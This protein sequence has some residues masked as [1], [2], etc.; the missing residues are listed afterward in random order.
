MKRTRLIPAFLLVVLAACQSPAGEPQEAVLLS[1]ATVTHGTSFGMCGGYCVSELVVDG[2]TVTFT[3]RSHGYDPAPRTRQVEITAAEA[4][5]IASLAT[6][7][8]VRPVAGV[9]G[10]PDCADGGAE[11]IEVKTSADSVKA[12]YQFGHDLDRIAELQRE[13]RALRERFPR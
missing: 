12:T 13:L 4:A 8:N 1:K 9:H 7:A 5:R 6:L 10:C 11:W 2:R 3:E